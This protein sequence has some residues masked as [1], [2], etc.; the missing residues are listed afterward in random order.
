MLQFIIFFIISLIGLSNIIFPIIYGIPKINSE[1]K[2]GN[3]KKDIPIYLILLPPTIWTVI[4]TILYYYL[5]QKH[6]RLINTFELAFIYSIFGLI[7]YYVT[8]RKKM[9]EDAENDFK[10]NYKEYFKN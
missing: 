9:L 7:F 4:F 6:N 2:K 1:K 5:F 3:L 10:K 8:N